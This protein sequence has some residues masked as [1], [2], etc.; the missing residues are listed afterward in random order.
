MP[1]RAKC[2]VGWTCSERI[3]PDVRVNKLKGSVSPTVKEE[4]DLV[5]GGM[6]RE[7]PRVA[8]HCLD[9][10]PAWWVDNGFLTFME[11]N[12]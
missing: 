7:W 5:A 6:F 2:R 3:K 12:Q 1:L 9:T 11:A 8:R 4:W 10:P